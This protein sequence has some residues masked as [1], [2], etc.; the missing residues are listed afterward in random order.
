MVI[1]V[2]HWL[3][4]ERPACIAWDQAEVQGCFESFTTWTVREVIRCIVRRNCDQAQHQLQEVEV[5]SVYKSTDIP[6]TLNS[7]NISKCERV[8]IQALK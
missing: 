2:G 8:I 7:L 3:C 4:H 1:A 5:I 6:A